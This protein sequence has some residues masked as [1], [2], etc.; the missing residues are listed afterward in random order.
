[1]PT[2]EVPV[3]FEAP[4]ASGLIAHFV[5]AVSGG[6]LYRKSSFLLDSLG[7]P[8]FSPLINIAERPHLP[9][10]QASSW[11]DDDGVATRERDVVKNGVLQGYFLGS[12]SARKLGMQTT[13][14]AGGN[15][16]LIVEPGR[17][18]AARAPPDPSWWRT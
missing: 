14:N 1:M 2:C 7:K 15:Y 9:R 3:L 13:G 6:S 5:S 10:A 18:D 11:F 17:D 12:Y 8:V 16:N 4:L